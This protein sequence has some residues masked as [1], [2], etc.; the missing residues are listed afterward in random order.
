MLLRHSHTSPYVRKVAVLV[1]ETGLVKRVAFET[2]D[3]WSEPDDLTSDNPLSMVP[4]LV[5]DDGMTLYDSAVICE[6]LDSL[7]AGPP[8]I[9]PTGAARDSS[10]IQITLLYRVSCQ[11]ER[12]CIRAKSSQ[13]IQVCSPTARWRFPL[14]RT[15]SPSRRP[16][17]TVK[18]RRRPVSYVVAAIVSRSI[19]SVS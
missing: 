11:F 5:L 9:P 4:T 17:E 13:L 1:H 3:G 7:H 12:R 14:I 15:T 2:V 16:R 10:R 8:M 6:Y 18:I 19:H